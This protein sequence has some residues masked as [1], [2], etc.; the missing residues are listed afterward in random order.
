MIQFSLKDLVVGISPLKEIGAW[1][2]VTNDFSGAKRVTAHKRVS[3][4]EALQTLKHLRFSGRH[5]FTCVSSP[6]DLYYTGTGF[7]EW[8]QSLQGEIL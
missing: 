2:I 8:N 4:K 6:V 1:L 5:N 3:R 7:G